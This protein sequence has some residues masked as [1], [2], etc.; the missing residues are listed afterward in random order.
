MRVPQA[1]AFALA[2]AALA[3]AELKEVA[4]C[5]TFPGR[6]SLELAKHRDRVERL[7][8]RA[9]PR[10]QQA[11]LLEISGDLVLMSDGFAALF[12]TYR[13]C[14]PHTFM[15]QLREQG[16]AELALRLRQIERDDAACVRYPRFKMSDDASAL[17]LRVG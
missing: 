16:L 11:S 6:G 17:W 7:A 1:T 8:R 2:I 4:L 3:S 9:G 14:T 12:D 10:A 15:T 5:G 13:A